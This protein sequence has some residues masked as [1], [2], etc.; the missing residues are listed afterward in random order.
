MKTRSEPLGP[1]AVALALAFLGCVFALAFNKIE[2][3][4]AWTHLSFGR[5]IWEH[6]A[7]PASEPYITTSPPFPYNNWLFGLT[8]YVAHGIGGFAGVITLKAVIV[9]GIFAVL[10]ALALRPRGNVLLAVLVLFTLA[11]MLRFRFVERPDTVMMLCLGL[12]LLCLEAFVAEGRK[13]IY[14]LPLVH[15]VW[16]NSH[17]SIVLM[18]VPFFA[19][20]AGGWLQGFTARHA[21]PRVSPHLL[22]FAPAPSPEQLKTI[23]LVFA[24]SLAASLLS[25]YFIDQYTH[26]FQAVQSDWWRQEITELNRPNWEHYKALYVLAGLILAS[27]LLNHRRV[28][29]VDAGIALPL[30]VLPF[31]AVRFMWFAAIGAVYLV[32]N[33]SE[34]AAEYRISWTRRPVVLAGALAAIVAATSL[35]L[36]RVKPLDFDPL[37]QTGVGIHY[38]MLPEGGLAYLDRAG[39]SGRVFNLFQWGGYIT[40]RDF[41]RRTAFI[42]GRG[43]LSDELLERAGRAITIP[44]VLDGLQREFR[45]ESVLYYVPQP[46]HP[47]EREAVR[48]GLALA[49]PNWALV[50]WDD[51]CMVLLRRKGPHEPVIA[52]DEYRYA[53]PY[54]DVDASRLGEPDYRA[55][56]FADLRRNV[57]ETGS[58]RARV[59]LGYALNE[60]GEYREAI[61]ALAGVRNTLFHNFE[62]D[63]HAQTGY[64][65]RMLGNRDEAIRSY[66]AALAAGRSPLVLQNLGLLYTQ[67]G[68]RREAIRHYEQALELNSSLVSVYRALIELHRAEG[69]TDAAEKIA[70]RLQGEEQVAAGRK[71]FRAG[72]HAYLAQNYALAISEFEKSIAANPANPAPYSNLGYVYYDM[73]NRDKAFEYHRRAVELDVNAANSYYGLALVYRDRKDAAQAIRHWQE[74]LRIEPTGL[75][76]RKAKLEIEALRR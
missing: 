27:F 42:D 13:W 68:L 55:G 34:F 14:A 2:D 33:L 73:G 45:F 44:E 5:W 38:A 43:F 36:L 32:R 70:V 75:Y 35:H 61:A 18:T 8:Y 69:D 52:R 48:A 54:A 25:P 39:V 7:I 29:L 16:A 46:Q 31:V 1:F 11:M 76:S 19:Y 17:T 23:S 66:E 30:L 64:A 47:V 72:T 40:W 15:W 57:R 20:L 71:H 4:D 41:P 9:T 67:K 63:A 60:V 49:Q 62:H 12:S 53:L 28:S 10:L 21:A 74:Y 37:K 6:G 24:L 50:Y 26:S 22:G 51:L 59:A 56:L 58:S 65:H 3:T